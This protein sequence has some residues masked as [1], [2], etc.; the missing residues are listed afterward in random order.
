MLF[1][2][3]CSAHLY[4]YLYLFLLAVNFIGVDL[5]TGADDG[6]D[7]GKVDIMLYGDIEHE[8]NIPYTGSVPGS[9]YF[10]LPTPYY[11]PDE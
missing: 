6:T 4:L 5:Y 3:L 9:S 10:S 7:S 1:S 8:V 11:I 2:Y